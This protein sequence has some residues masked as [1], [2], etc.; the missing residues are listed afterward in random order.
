MKQSESIY[1]RLDPS[2]QEVRLIE[3]VTTTPEVTCRLSTA[4]LHD[5]PSFCALSYVWGD[6]YDTTDIIVS[7]RKHSVTKNLL[8]A[9]HHT[10]LHWQRHHPGRDIAE[11]RV[12]ADSLCINQKDEE[13]KGH[14]VKMMGL[15]YS[16]AELVLGSLGFCPQNSQTPRAIS[17]LQNIQSYI[18]SSKFEPS[19]WSRPLTL[20]WISDY[21]DLFKEGGTTKG[22]AQTKA[23]C[24]AIEEFMSSPYW[25][26]AWIVQEMVLAKTCILF[27]GTNAVDLDTILYVNAWRLKVIWETP[28]HAIPG[29]VRRCFFEMK[30]MDGIDF[31]GRLRVGRQLE[32]RED[33]LSPS[34][35]SESHGLLYLHIMSATRR[36][37]A[38]NLKDYVYAF[39]NLSNS[40]IV[41]DYSDHKS[42]QSVYV[43]ACAECLQA[44]L[45]DR[46]AEPL[47]FLSQG[48]IC[49]LNDQD[50]LT[51]IPSWTPVFAYR[52]RDYRNRPAMIF[53]PPSNLPRIK[54]SQS[55]MVSWLFPEAL[56]IPQVRKHYLIVAGVR[57]ARVLETSMSIMARQDYSGPACFLSVRRI[58]HGFAN[59]NGEQHP[60]L[61]LARALGATI[62][63]CGLWETPDAIVVVRLLQI[64]ALHP[65]FTSDPTWAYYNKKLRSY[66]IDTDA[67]FE[68]FKTNNTLRPFDHTASMADAPNLKNINFSMETFLEDIGLGPSW[69]DAVSP[70]LSADVMECVNGRSDWVTLIK[71]HPANAG[72]LQFLAEVSSTQK[73]HEFLE[74]PKANKLYDWLPKSQPKVAIANGA[75][76]DHLGVVPEPCQKGDVIVVL[77]CSSNLALLRPV[78]HYYRFVGLCSFPTLSEA[79]S[80]QMELGRV[81]IVDFEIR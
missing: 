10:H 54:L 25:T 16:T 9:L 44:C 18:R 38:N 46:S 29:T 33:T 40:N 41:P 5:R 1:T 73:F 71:S 67:L 31:I 49:S 36:F 77:H 15:I 57:I 20:S 48:G 42:F 28:P 45:R 14:Q 60:I 12:W 64:Q 8:E 4:S 13:E 66:G 76:F 11:C 79:V 19:D 7:T 69:I 70:G 59:R 22:D 72:P 39:I 65:H 68:S 37:K 51:E 53:E 6:E 35:R 17:L 81:S 47:A 27:H 75:R 23:A 30:N 80:L 62:P 43:E 2:R 21:H 52:T 63:D 55:Q 32:R 61:A 34:T 78:H 58:L 3:I 56:R 74:S 50:F 26:R 24:D